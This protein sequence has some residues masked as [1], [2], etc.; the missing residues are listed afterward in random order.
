[1]VSFAP[2]IAN[3][4]LIT[5]SIY[6]WNVAFPQSLWDVLLSTGEV[7]CT[8]KTLMPPAPQKEVLG[9]NNHFFFPYASNFVFPT[10]LPIKPS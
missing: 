3:I 7:M 9:G 4:D 5:V 1:M 6:P 2:H 8:L 10:L